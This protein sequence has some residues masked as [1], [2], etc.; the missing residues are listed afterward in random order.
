MRR[1]GATKGR[2]NRA[3]FGLAS[4]VCVVGRTFTAVVTN[5]LGPGQK[6]LGGLLGLRSSM[7]DSGTGFVL[8]A[9]APTIEFFS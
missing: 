9:S 5:V 3:C 8:Y 7:Y 1:R 2:G 4:S 6:L